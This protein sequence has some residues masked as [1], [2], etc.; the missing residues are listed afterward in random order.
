MK[1]DRCDKCTYWVADKK[2]TS[3]ECHLTAPAVVSWRL[4]V[5]GRWPPV[6]ATDWCGDFK[7]GES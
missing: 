6:R 3:G 4:D 1:T 2:A 7:A 5:A